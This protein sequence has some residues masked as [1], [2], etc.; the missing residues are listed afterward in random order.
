MGLICTDDNSTQPVKIEELSPKED[1][2]K[3]S[4]SRKMS[5]DRSKRE[6]SSLK[7]FTIYTRDFVG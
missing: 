4:I 1:P 5:M 3:F 2:H 7:D 6:I